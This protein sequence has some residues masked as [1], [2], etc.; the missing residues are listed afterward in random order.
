MS[1]EDL[2]NTAYHEL[3]H[4]YVSQVMFNE[5]RGGD[6]V[7]KITIIPRARALGYTQSLPKGDRYNYTKDNLRARIM[8]AMGG[9]AAQEIFLNTVD[10]GASNDFEQATNIARQMVTKFGMSELGPISVGDPGANP[11]LGRAMASEV[12]IS[13]SLQSKID[14]QWMKIVN[15]CYAETKA[16][17]ERDRAC[18]KHIADILLEQETIL[19]PQWEQLFNE[20]TCQQRKIRKIELPADQVAEEPCDTCGQPDAQTGG[21]PLAHRILDAINPAHLL[22]GLR[23]KDHNDQSE[24]K[25]GEKK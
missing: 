5:N 15:E 2:E 10:T 20:S 17:I 12:T 14:D 13:A 1:K 9:R 7:T 24:G 16:L 23:G 11:F 19:G 8:M 4:A 6:P 3:G 18:F 22:K 25:D 21:E